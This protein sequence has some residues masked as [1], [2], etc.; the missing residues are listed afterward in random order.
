MQTIRV[1]RQIFFVS[2]CGQSASQPNI[3]GM[4]L[5]TFDTSCQLPRA[6]ILNVR[7]ERPEV[8][9]FS[10]VTEG[11]ASLSYDVLAIPMSPSS[12]EKALQAK[13]RGWKRRYERY[14]TDFPLKA[15][16]LRETCYE[17]LQGRC[18][19]IGHG[20]MGAVFTAECAKG[21]VISL[22]FS[23]PDHATTLV[24]R[25]I[26]RYRKGFLHGLEFLGLT[27]EQ[28]DTIGR[29]CSNLTPSS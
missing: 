9:A 7:A 23:L 2:R 14:R 1:A 24:V 22:E 25:S 5:T 19:D 21:E 16:I 29:Y 11:S 18:G 4:S 27:D 20:G 6:D 12:L 13:Q 3:D 26:V 28:L 17:E 15:K 10:A 8:A